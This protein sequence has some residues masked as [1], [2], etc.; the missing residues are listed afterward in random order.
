MPVDEAGRVCERVD[1]CTSPIAP[2]HMYTKDL[3]HSP[4][5]R[6]AAFAEI[7]LHLY[8]QD[9]SLQDYF[10]AL[11]MDTP[12]GPRANLGNHHASNQLRSW[13]IQAVDKVSQLRPRRKIKAD[14]L[15]CWD[16][17]FCRQTEIRFFVRTLL[18]I[19]QTDAT[20]LCL[21]PA[22]ASCREEVDNQL[23]AAG[24]SGQVTFVDPVAPLDSMDAQLRPR[25]TRMRG[26]SA[27][28]KTVQILEPYGLSPS[29][30][31]EAKFNHF[32]YFVESW[33]RLAPS[34]EFDAVVTRCHW[35]ALCS[36]VCR[37]ALQRGKPVITFQQGV[38]GHSL[39]VP[40]T[41]SKYVAFGQPS[42]SFLAQLNRRFFQAAEMH[43]P[44]VEYVLGGCLFDTVTP[45][46][47]QFDHRTVLIV[48]VPVLPDDFYG[49]QGQGQALLQ[50]AE[51]L[52]EADH[53]LRSVVIR[54][55]PYWNS[56]DLE[57]CKRLVREYST[58]CQL[59][60]PGW[61][62]ED[63]LRRSSVVVG[64]IS[65]VLT[66]AS[67]CGLPAV[68]LQT[69]QGFTTCDLACFSPS[70]TLLPEA[71]FC[72]ISKMLKD[73]RVYAQARTN[74]RQNGR[75]YYAHGTNLDFSGAFFERLLRPESVISQARHRSNK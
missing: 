3:F 59:S 57:A 45:L 21:L 64:I 37:T 53:P 25:S 70:Q 29:S 32:A 10:M 6:I 65:G 15:L 46:P 74:A 39:D 14:V 60:H 17:Y 72:E 2:F 11:Q 7:Q 42:A 18:G 47:D 35:Q 43:E 34:V 1:L 28:E 19:A 71:A 67:A 49:M 4:A 73:G 33:E 48:D 40:V 12:A 27:L 9:V 62:L 41:A 66:V 24:R 54:P 55:H 69:E 16:P 38:I 75:E 22:G 63:D 13:A 58:R 31:V 8:R 52:L 56:L 50:L 68:F 30:E 23:S 51:R 61:T 20:I 5:D 26:R 36:P 44:P